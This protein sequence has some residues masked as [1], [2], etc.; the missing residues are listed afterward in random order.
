MLHPENA[1]FPTT[2]T[3][4]GKLMLER[5]LQPGFD[6]PPNVHTLFTAQHSPATV[7]VLTFRWFEHE[8]PAAEPY[9]SASDR[10]C[11]LPQPG[12]DQPPNV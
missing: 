1:W 10:G 8:H 7:S 9:D 11:C 4:P 12:F 3:L 2:V 6:Q 5:L